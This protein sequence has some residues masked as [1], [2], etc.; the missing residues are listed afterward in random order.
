MSSASGVRCDQGT[1][2][3]PPSARTIRWGSFT[4]VA[5]VAALAVWT[6]GRK[7]ANPAS[8]ALPV[9]TALLCV[10]LCFLFDDPAAETSSGSATPLLLRRGVR[11][12]IAVPAAASAW[13]ACTWIGPL[14][15]PT[16]AM[17]ISFGALVLVALGAGAAAVRVVGGSRSGLFAAAVVVFVALVLPVA[18]GRPPT[19]DPSLPPWGAPAA[20]WGLVAALAVAV[21]VTAH[22]DPARPS[23]RSRAR[24]W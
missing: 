20:Y 1:L 8:F 7:G 6:G 18:A 16:G 9:A 4:V 23:A 10:W 11:A 5:G 21:L 2:L 15:G 14:T 17:T 12:A 13:F 3:V 22:R 19:V 24:R